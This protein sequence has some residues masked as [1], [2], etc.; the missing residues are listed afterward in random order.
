M[1]LLHPPT[2]QTPN[3]LQPRIHLPN[4]NGVSQTATS[5]SLIFLQIDVIFPSSSDLESALLKLE[6]RYFR[7]KAKLSELVDYAVPLASSLPSP[8]MYVTPI[9]FHVIT[10]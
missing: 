9:A 10:C 5:L 4:R 3:T 1:C 8:N 6:T 2:A 7:G